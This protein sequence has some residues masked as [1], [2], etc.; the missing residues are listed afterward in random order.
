MGD[1]HILQALRPYLTRL[2]K[3]LG[4]GI[5]REGV[6]K[7]YCRRVSVT[8]NSLTF[9]F[10]KGILESLSKGLRTSYFSVAITRYKSHLRIEGL[11]LAYSLRVHSASGQEAIVVVAERQLVMLCPQSGSRKR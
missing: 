11:V 1:M 3:H 5:G 9:R 2:L 4:G 7:S 6:L 8:I 10:C